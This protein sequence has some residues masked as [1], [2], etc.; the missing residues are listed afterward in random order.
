MANSSGIQKLYNNCL[1][2]V[3]RWLNKNGFQTN[4]VTALYRSHS[5]KGFLDISL[6]EPLYFSNW[7]YRPKSRDKIDIVADV[8]ERVRLSDG[9]SVKSTCYFNYFRIEND[10]RFA[11]DSIHFDFEESVQPQHPICHAQ[12]LSTTIETLPQGFPEHVDKSAI[13]KRHQ[14]IRIP[15]SF[16]NLAGLFETITADHLPSNKYHDFWLTCSKYISA[17]PVHADCDETKAINN[18][19]DIRSRNWYRR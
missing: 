1:S 16:V 12:N 6:A 8:K 5:N 17:I 9:K 10:I 13:E 18:S 15:T 4:S 11:C 19:N 3:T 14:A 2:E 7:P